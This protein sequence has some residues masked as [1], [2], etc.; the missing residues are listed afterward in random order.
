MKKSDQLKQLRAQ[1]IEAQKALHAKAEGEKRS[2]NEAETTEFRA[3]QTEIE[4]LGG[5]IADALAYEENL[6]SLEG[7]EPVPGANAG[8]EERGG[9]KPAQ[10]KTFSLNKAIRSLVNGVALEG[11]EL[12]ANQRGI[13]AA[14]AA[15]IG[16]SPSSFT[17]PL[18]DTRSVNF[19]TRADGQTVGEDTGGYG[20]NTV[21]TDV[22][23]PIDY[24]RPK[25]VVESLGAV[26][27]TGLQ[28]NVQFP[29]NNG[30]V[31]ATWEGEV[32]EVTNTKNAIGKIEMS[33]KRLA[34]SVLVSLQ[35]LM[36][37]SFDM[38]VYTMTEI[39]KAIENEI[40]KAAL[41]GASGGNS[42][43]GVLNT[44]GVNTYAVGT[45]GGPLTFAGAVQLETEVYVDNANGARMSYVSNSKV[46]GKAKTTVL[47][48]GQATY[49][50]QNN[51]MNGYPF[52]NSNHIPSNLTKGSTSGAC[53]AIIFGDFSQMVV[54]QWGFMD[55]SVDDKSRKKEGY[56][57]IT[58]NVYLDVAL[59][60][61]TAFTVCKDLT[62]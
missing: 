12:E 47:E 43:V 34:V 52:V 35:N 28:G 60:Q 55:I 44:S 18:F 1:K 22:L 30:G 5:Q 31:E 57:E 36:Q 33:P 51:E 8:S 7:N 56:I 58:A 62:T 11:A 49:L 37:S 6:R 16:L 61:P 20:G 32:A 41:A 45:N 46:R 13:A 24:L 54:G 23:A 10:K 50:L 29:K 48:S 27:L 15:G 14:R 40:D 3:L 59:K 21:A 4:G 38:E 19:E 17:L 2:L 26:F 25:P 42:P 53:S 9:N 39:R